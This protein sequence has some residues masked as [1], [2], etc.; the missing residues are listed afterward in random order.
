MRVQRTQVITNGDMSGNIVSNG[1][2]V[3]QHVIASIQVVMIGA[4]VGMLVAQHSND[5]VALAPIV[6]GGN[7]NQAANVVNWIDYTPV[8]YAVTGPNQ[9]MMLYEKTY[10]LWM[11]LKYVWGSGSGTLVSA[12]IVSKG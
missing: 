3:E 8:E 10:G 4:P 2:W 6:S 1:I 12:I 9:V 7:Q 5:I 11:R